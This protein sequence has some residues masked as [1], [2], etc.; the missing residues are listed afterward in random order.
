MQ[1][2]KDETNT[3]HEIKPT[4]TPQADKGHPKHELLASSQERK[5]FRST[6]MPECKYCGTQHAFRKEL[7]PGFGKICSSC[8]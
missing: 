3:V 2:I 5:K 8:G 4:L 7:F 6:R 1:E